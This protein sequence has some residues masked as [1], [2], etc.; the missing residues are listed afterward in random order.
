MEPPSR[1]GEVGGSSGQEGGVERKRSCEVG[2]D[3]GVRRGARLA[4][5]ELCV[6]TQAVCCLPP[7]HRAGGDIHSGGRGEGPTTMLLA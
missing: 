3:G 4:G 2:G 1:G 6:C 5:W 7:F